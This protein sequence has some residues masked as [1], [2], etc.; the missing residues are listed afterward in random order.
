M[1]YLEL[2]NSVLRRLR[3]NTVATV[4]QSAYSQLVGMYINDT[5]RQV[6]DAWNWDALDD[7]LTVSVTAGVTVYVV[8]GSGL[9]PKDVKVN[10]ATSTSQSTV[11]NRPSR[12]ITDQQQLGTVSA[13]SPY[14]FAWVGND[15][16]DSKIEIF[17]TP[18]SSYTLKVNGSFPPASLSADADVLTA[19]SEPV[20]AGAFARALVERGE[21][22]GLSSSEAYSVFKSVLSDYIAL[23][24]THSDSNDCWVAV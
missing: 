12:W 13:G 15:G 22:G 17:P 9:R 21:D 8:T 1:T 18:D 23:E 2:V 5:K 3:E 4:S 24:S 11:R 16:T 19:P 6:E 7:S 10:N 20:I 14:C